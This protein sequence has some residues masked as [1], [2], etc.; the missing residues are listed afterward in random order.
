MERFLASRGDTR[1]HTRVYAA[2]QVSSCFDAAKS[3]DLLMELRLRRV[4]KPSII[5]YID[6]EVGRLLSDRPCELGQNIFVTIQRANP[7]ASKGHQPRFGTW[8]DSGA[9]KGILEKG[10]LMPERDVL[11]KD[12]KFDFVTYTDDPP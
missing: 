9:R 1:T 12:E 8:S 10:Y 11:P 3:R 7:S 5:R 4:S 6:E 2:H